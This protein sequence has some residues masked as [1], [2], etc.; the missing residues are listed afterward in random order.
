MTIPVADAR[1]NERRSVTMLA[2]MS[3]GW[4][5]CRE[6]NWCEGPHVGLIRQLR[7]FGRTAAALATPSALCNHDIPGGCH[8]AWGIRRLS[9]NDP[10][11]GPPAGPP[12]GPSGP[13]SGAPGPSG[14]PSAI[15]VPGP[16]AQTPQAA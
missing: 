11:Q 10:T 4:L 15:G 6:A 3:V 1:V 7:L 16:A 14:P 9:D 2:P 8:R 12:P 5:G 13:P